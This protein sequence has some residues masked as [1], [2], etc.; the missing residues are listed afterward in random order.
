MPTTFFL[1]GIVCGIPTILLSLE[2]RKIRTDSRAMINNLEHL[3]G[4]EELQGLEVARDF[5]QL[6]S[7]LDS[8]IEE[9]GN[10][11]RELVSEFVNWPNDNFGKKLELAINETIELNQN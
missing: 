9:R 8:T 7:L 10:N 5:T 3:F 11:S 1:E 6:S 4:I 2:S